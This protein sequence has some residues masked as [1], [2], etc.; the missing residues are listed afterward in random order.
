ME[1]QKQLQAL[2]NEYQSLQNGT[3]PRDPDTQETKISR[4][5]L[6]K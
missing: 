4:I 3:P 6:K 5:K 1:Q 2:T